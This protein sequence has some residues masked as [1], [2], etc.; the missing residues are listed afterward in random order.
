MAKTRY[1]LAGAGGRGLGMFARPLVNDFADRAELVALFDSNTRR[2]EF[3]CEDLGMA[4]P[5]FT[6]FDEMLATADPDAVIVCTKDSTHA[7]F[8][9]KSLAAGKRSISEKPLCVN[10]EQCRAIWAAAQESSAEGVVTHNMRYGPLSSEMKRRVKDGQIGTLQRM[11][12]A[13]YLDRVHGADY[14]RRWHRVKANSGGLLIHKAS[15]HFDF[16]NWVAD[17]L[18]VK[19]YAQGDLRIYGARNSNFRGERCHGC[20]HAGRCDYYVDYYSNERM[21]KQYFE[22]E[23]IDG[24]HRD[25]CVFDPEI[26]IEDQVAAIV[27]Y[28]NDVL[29]SYDL[30]AYAPYEGHRIVL[31]GVDGRLEYESVSSTQWLPGAKKF[32]TSPRTAGAS[33][34]FYAP[35]GSS[36]KIEAEKV[37]GGHGGSDTLLRQDLFGEPAEDPLGRQAPLWEGLQAVLVGA[38]CNQSIATGEVAPG[39]GAASS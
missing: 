13:E 28:E 24:Y 9:V 17:A 5:T 6:D 20:E 23:V 18:P 3:A 31:E 14:F 26:D 32:G 39:R 25:G 7:E 34:W 15:H 33:L 11:Y 21:R 30:V 8:M 27:R 29:L 36:E 19:A 10:G 4:I 37:E 2:L 16:L 12:F 1:A 22:A 35:D 38:A